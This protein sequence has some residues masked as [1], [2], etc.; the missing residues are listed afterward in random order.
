LPLTQFR[1]IKLGQ[2]I[3]ESPKPVEFSFEREA[4]V[5]ANFAVVLV[6]TE[7]GSL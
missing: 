7:S 1:W 4:A 2:P 5:I 6:K 3:I